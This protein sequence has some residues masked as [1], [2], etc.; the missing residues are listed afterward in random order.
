MV[1]H[2]TDDIALPGLSP[3]S[4][5]GSYTDRAAAS[6]ASP[7]ALARRRHV[8]VP[9]EPDRCIGILSTTHVS[10]YA[11]WSDP[12]DRTMAS[13]VRH[14][15]ATTM[16]Q[17]TPHTAGAAGPGTRGYGMHN[18]LSLCILAR[19]IRPSGD[20]GSLSRFAR[21]RRTYSENQKQK[22]RTE[23]RWHGRRPRHSGDSRLTAHVTR[24]DP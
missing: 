9:I 21:T 3:P 11:H 13:P 12:I 23:R 2:R 6:G 24:Q 7:E 20:G 14:P 8:A 5:Y 17:R 16:A 18:A 19:R 1:K 4:R 22:P 10:P 15:E